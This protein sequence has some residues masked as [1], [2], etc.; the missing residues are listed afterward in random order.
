MNVRIVGQDSIAA[1]GVQQMLIMIPEAC[2]V[3]IILAVGYL[4]NALNVR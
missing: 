4:K 1:A 3:Y 2:K